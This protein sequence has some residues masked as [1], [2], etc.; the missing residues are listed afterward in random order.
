[1]NR[2]DLLL[3]FGGESSEHDVSIASASNV[4]AALSKDKYEIQLCYID[5]RGRWWLVDHIAK[6]YNT[7]STMQLSVVPGSASLITL[8]GGKVIEPDVILPILHGKNGEDGSV[9][10]LAQLLHIPIVGCDLTSSAICMDKLI[11]KQIAQSYGI[12]VAPSLTYRRG[13]SAV[14]FADAVAKLDN[15][16]FIKPSRSGS[17]VGVSKVDSSESYR[18]ALEQALE[19]GDTV[20]IESAIVGREIE[21][22]VLGNPPRHQVSQ[23]GEVKSDDFYSYNQKYSQA[24]TSQIII[25]S[26]LD[27][28]TERNLRRVASQLYKAFGCNGLARIDFFV[29]KQNQIYFNE[30]NTMPGFTDT[31]M[32]PKL[33]TEQGASY[34]DLLDTMISLV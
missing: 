16:L 8:L 34:S 4:L 23:T 11:A 9:Q 27:K 14:D 31:S 7:K 17:S 24:S 19:H 2:T 25:P 13:E 18:V 12:K 3:V 10:G 15:T 22:A 5:R 1:M 30:I 29:T 20:L 33:W 32:Y 26:S 28:E 21:V 6:N